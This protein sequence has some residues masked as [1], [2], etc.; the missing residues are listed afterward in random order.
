MR[1]NTS[2]KVRPL[3]SLRAIVLACGCFA[4]EEKHDLFSLLRDR[5]AG[6]PTEFRVEGLLRLNSSG[7]AATR[8][9]RIAA[10]EDAW[11][12]ASQAPTPYRS[13]IGGRT[14]TRAF[15]EVWFHGLDALSLQTR[16]LE[17]MSALEPHGALER[18]RSMPPPA[19]AN[20]P[21]SILGVPNVEA[22]YQAAVRLLKAAEARAR[23]KPDV[24]L[25]FGQ[26][27]MRSATSTAHLPGAILAL[28]SIPASEEERRLW[29]ITLAGAVDHMDSSDR[30]L[31]ALEARHLAPLDALLQTEPQAELLAAALRGL[32]LRQ[33][34]KAVCSNN[35]ASPKRA[36]LVRSVNRLLTVADPGG[37]LQRPIVSEE[38]AHGRV[39]LT[40]PNPAF[41]ESAASRKL[42]E[43]LQT[44]N[45]IHPRSEQPRAVRQPGTEG[46]RAP[47]A[48]RSAPS[49]PP[50]P[51]VSSDVF[52]NAIA[53]VENWKERSEA[54]FVE[55]YCMKAGAYADIARTAPPELADTATQKLLRFV[56]QGYQRIENRNLWF[57]PVRFALA[58]AARAFRQSQRRDTL[59]AMRLSA[60]SVISLYAE[61][62]LIPRKK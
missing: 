8:D 19:V 30:V 38:L 60:N 50:D 7:V 40:P 39:E 59:E 37:Q 53:Q 25:R 2:P 27:L 56:E 22:Y 26:D 23:L 54:Y 21:C 33:S 55:Y 47:S 13:V 16:V 42:L 61:L 49:G 32:V 20:V 14:D 36:D 62:E 45:R 9:A 46:Q 52:A 29:T 58:D 44:L 5:A 35:V 31:G 3:K 41:W 28:T 48:P 6:L 51:L 17:A 12:A 10:L 4:Q 18:F 15:H 34:R 43:T 11:L 1:E 24:R 57:T